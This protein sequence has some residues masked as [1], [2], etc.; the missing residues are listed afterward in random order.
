M[1][2]LVPLAGGAVGAGIYYA[3]LALIGRCR[4]RRRDVN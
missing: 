4:R 2:L 1:D 3:V